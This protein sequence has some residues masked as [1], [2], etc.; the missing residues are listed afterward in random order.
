MDSDPIVD[1]LEIDCRAALVSQKILGPCIPD[2]W[3]KPPCFLA[4]TVIF[5]WRVWPTGDNRRQI[6]AWVVEF[7]IR[8]GDR[9]PGFDLV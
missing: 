3:A 2:Q 6:N 4:I 8:L 5:A 7:Q 9:Y 1:G